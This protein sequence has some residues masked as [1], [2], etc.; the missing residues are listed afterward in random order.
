MENKVR[1]TFTGALKGT[2]DSKMMLASYCY[3][4]PCKLRG[5]VFGGLR[6]V[7]GL[8]SGGLWA[9]F[10]G[11][12]KCLWGGREAFG[13]FSGGFWQILSRSSAGL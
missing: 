8:S 12:L 4:Q 2:L 11:S 5:G 1:G 9:V 3:E 10:G 6:G 13:R 7:F